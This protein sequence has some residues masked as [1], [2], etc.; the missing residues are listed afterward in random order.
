MRRPHHLV[1]LVAVAAA[2][3]ATLAIAPST[4]AAVRANLPAAMRFSH[5]VVVDEQRVGFEPGVQVDGKDRIWSSVPQGSSQTISNI[6]LSDDHG[7]TYRLAP[8]NVL[9][10]G[11]HT[12]CPQGGGDTELALDKKGDLFFSDL[13]NLSNLSN[14]VTTDGGKTFST[15]CLSVPN[16]PVDRMWY[17]VHG[18]LGDPDFVIYETYDAIESTLQPNNPAGNQ[19]VEVASTD[20]VNF[21]LVRNDDV[22]P[23]C[24]GLGVADCVSDN[25]G[26][27]GNQVLDKSTGDLMI[28][29]TSSDGNQVLVDRGHVVHDATGFHA[30]W[31]QTVLNAS[32]CPDTPAAAKAGEI[33]G[34]ALF[35][36]IAED[37]AGHYY[38]VFA[39]NHT[40]D[41]D[42]NG[43]VQ[44]GPYAVYM[45][46][47]M[48]GVHWGTPF[49]VSAGGS[50]AFPWVTAGDPGRVAVSY[51]H[52]T[53]EKE[54]G[55]Y[56]FDD[57]KHGSFTVELSE[58]LNALSANPTFRQNTVSEHPIK[59]G[60]IC[61]Q[62]TACTVSMGD[63]SL[64]DYLQ[65]GHDA[66]GAVLVAYVDDTSNAYT[67]GP[68][69]GQSQ[70]V[71]DLAVPC[72]YADAGPVGL[73]RQI[74]G[75]SLFANPGTVAGPGDG[76]G[77]EMDQTSDP[78]G[79]AKY[80][81]NGSLTSAPAALDLT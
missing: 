69:C 77:V 38:V 61:T 66:R 13:Q 76:P 60:P 25:E 16:T 6:W 65:D 12:T 32:L 23:D 8:G 64:G 29:H 71:Q 24:L 21:Q 50:N 55:S 35:A 45:V 36:T 18:N 19:L 49:K 68:T 39:S 75:P 62:G 56:V 73:V 78:T 80:S 7:K 74:G 58:S 63:R 30:S 42:G 14:S 40:V 54:N 53:E 48:D 15:S 1:P 9:G 41:K 27:P 37:T 17:A 31:K 52:A 5:E 43:S 46:T 59:Y 28:A 26:I 44:D 70:D 3:A 10:T 4:S 34:A 72:Q 67:P 11:R 2:G 57:L 81:A 51:Y 20:G 33:C 79:D 47:S 22:G